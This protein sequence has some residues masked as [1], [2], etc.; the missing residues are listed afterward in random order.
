[1]S[2]FWAD[3]SN[4]VLH[5]TNGSGKLLGPAGG[6]IMRAFRC[7]VG[8]VLLQLIATS[9]ATYQMQPLSKSN[10]KSVIECDVAVTRSFFMPQY[11]ALFQA[12]HRPDHAEM[13][14]EQELAHDI[15]LFHKIA[16]GNGGSHRSLVATDDGCVVGAVVWEEQG[17]VATLEVLLVNEYI[18]EQVVTTALVDSIQ[19]TRPHL[20][21][22]VV[23]P[24]RAHNEAALSLY[25]HLGFTQVPYDET[26]ASFVGIDK[27]QLFTKLVKKC[28]SVV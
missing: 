5:H 11:T 17:V 28:P 6:R 8:T 16:A 1:M 18:H 20:K 25:K 2:E 22:V 15:A 3:S 13:Q 21:E 27:A 4:Q 10:L 9:Y 12:F 23:K 19:T 14:L 7:A 24:L 26:G